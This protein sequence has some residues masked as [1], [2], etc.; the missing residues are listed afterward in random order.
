GFQVKSLVAVWLPPRHI[1]RQSYHGMIA[2]AQYVS[3][4]CRH[5]RASAF[6]IGITSYLAPTGAHPA[7]R[8]GVQRLPSPEMMRDVQ[9]AGPTSIFDFPSDFDIAC[10]ALSLGCLPLSLVTSQ[11][12]AQLSPPLEV[13][14]SGVHGRGVYATQFIP[15]GTRIIEYTGQR[16]SW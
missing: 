4:I 7:I 13:R 2:S 12:S 9:S 14:R 16:V 5:S 1:S 3:L 10:S 11:R 15:E 6:P 8:S